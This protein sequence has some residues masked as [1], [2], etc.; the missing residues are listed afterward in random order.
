MI[1]NIFTCYLLL[2]VL[3]VGCNLSKSN[4]NKRSYL[5]EYVY[6]NDLMSV[7][8]LLKD[9]SYIFKHTGPGMFKQYSKGSYEI[10]GQNL[11]L[12]S[13]YT[14]LFTEIKPINW[15]SFKEDKIIIRRNVIVYKGYYLRKKKEKDI[16]TQKPTN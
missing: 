9:S 8:L 12:K 3:S 10:E 11:V 5:G 1:K 14:G 4:L 7:K 2:A 16:P 13:I 6:L 15:K